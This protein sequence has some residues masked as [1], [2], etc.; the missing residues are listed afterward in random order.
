MSTKK[1][2]CI[3]LCLISRKKEQE[4]MF[5]SGI[6]EQ[7]ELALQA[8]EAKL[9][10]VFKADYLVAHPDLIARNKGNVML[11]PTLLFT[12]IAYATEKIGV[13]TTASTSFYPPYILARQLQSLNWISNGR[14]GWNI[15]TSID[16]AENFGETGMPPSE[17]RYAKA[18]ECTELVR[19]L[20]RSHPYEV[21]KVDNTEVI[22]EMVKP[23]EHSGEYFE[24]KGPLNIPQHISGEMPLFQ[25]GASE[26]GRNFAASVAD[27]IF[28]AMPDIESGIELRQN[29]RR[30]AEKHGRKQDDVRVLPGLYFFIGDTYEEALEMHRQAHQHLTMEKRLALLEMVLG[31]DARGISLESKIKEDMLPSREQTVRSKTHAELLRNFIIKNEPTVE[32]I[33]ERPE[34]VG[35]AHWVAIGTPQD[36]FQQIMERFE[37]GALDGFI[38]IPGGPQKSLD[39][40]FS[41]VIP[42][43]VKA[44]I[45]REEYT[46]ST[47]REHL[48]GTLSNTL[49]LK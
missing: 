28:A 40:F 18:A 2:L 49:L 39:L 15:V 46:G 17:E 42:L 7:V 38:A 21:L 6:D 37:A 14:V 24:V 22:R 12:A 25:A 9:D 4:S 47:L 20:W 45:F 10:F 44:G 29:L 1:K 30:R 19:K 41:E 35:S 8:E 11:D 48:E 13:V 27:A 16:G 32:Q 3:G 26:A 36:V 43:F 33:L 34:V 31:L 23:I 5:N